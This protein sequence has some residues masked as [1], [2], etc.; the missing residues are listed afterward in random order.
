MPRGARPGRQLDGKPVL[1]VSGGDRCLAWSA[2]CGDGGVPSLAGG[3]DGVQ[4]A[5]QGSGEHGVGLPDG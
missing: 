4:L 5:Q 1:W 2:A 3:D